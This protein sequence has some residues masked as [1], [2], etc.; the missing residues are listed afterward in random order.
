MPPITA[1]YGRAFAS[2]GLAD[3]RLP[4]ARERHLEANGSDFAT[5]CNDWVLSSV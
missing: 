5:G 4:T 1:D 2:L 3:C